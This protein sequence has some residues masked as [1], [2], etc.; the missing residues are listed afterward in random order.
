MNSLFRKWAAGVLLLFLVQPM[1]SQVQV[2]SWNIQHMG[3]SKSDSVIDYMAKLLRKADVVALQ[4]VVAGSGGAQAVARLADALNRTGA[5]WDYVVSDPTQSSSPN[6]RERYAFLWKKSA[7]TL[8]GKAWLDSIH[9]T[10]MEREPYLARFKHKNQAFT[11]VNFHALP[12]TSQPE[13]ELKYLKDF[14]VRYPTHRLLFLGDFNCPS[15]HTVFEPLRKLGY[16]PL[17]EGQ[18][19]TLRQKCIN[20]DCLANP[21]DHI[22]IPTSSVRVEK[23]GVIH[24]YNDFASIK[25]ARKV[26][27]HIPIWTELLF[28]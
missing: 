13:K 6:R 9:P 16:F 12:K 24:F 22:W 23:C 27:D 14:V 1:W 7:V 3:K 17:F 25:Q 8:Q 10:L 5:A 11:L 26:S 15:T 28:F 18:K 20:N 21:F 19:T 2:V 4:E